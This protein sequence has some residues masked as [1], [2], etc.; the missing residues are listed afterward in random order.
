MG[1]FDLNIPFREFS[2]SGK[3]TIDSTRTKLVVKAMELG[4]TGITYNRTIRGVMSDHHRCS[5]SLLTLSSLLKLAPSPSSSVKL[6]RDLLGIP[7]ATPFG[8]YRRLTIYIDSPAQ[9]QALNSGKP[10]LKTYDLVAVKPLNQSAFDQACERLEV[11]VIV[12]DFS[13]KLPFRLKQ[14][15]VKAAAEI[16]KKGGN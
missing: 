10:I 8:Q 1:F 7:V 12:I 16:F 14:P 13:A 4:Y 2:P 5:I 6:H 11:D 9:S 3:A 15:L